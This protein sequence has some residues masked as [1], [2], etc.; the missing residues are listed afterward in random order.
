MTRHYRLLVEVW[1]EGDADTV[2]DLA[3]VG[4]AI[5]IEEGVRAIV[6]PLNFE[7]HAGEAGPAIEDWGV[8]P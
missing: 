6:L 2:P 8:E 4:A 1:I 3:D 7:D 5:E